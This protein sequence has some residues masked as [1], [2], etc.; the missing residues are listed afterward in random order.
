MV[1]CPDCGTRNDYCGKCGCPLRKGE[2]EDELDDV[3][4]EQ[5]TTA[6]IKPKPEIKP[7]R[8]LRK[9][10]MVTSSI[11]LLF[12]SIWLIASAFVNRS[13]GETSNFYINMMIGILLLII[14]SSL[15]SK[16]IKRARYEV[17]HIGYARTR[18][19]GKKLII[20]SIVGIILFITILLTVS[21]TI[22]NYQWMLHQDVDKLYWTNLII[23]GIIATIIEI[24][25]LVFISIMIARGLLRKRA[26]KLAS[27]TT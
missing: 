24:M 4:R 17:D 3:A 1:R 10:L 26:L 18:K 22:G 15:L 25:L 19:Q 6:D 11:I 8:H 9:Y 7:S 13:E 2:T 14:A 12:Y 16:L 23:Y 21:D 27:A 5:A 20:Y